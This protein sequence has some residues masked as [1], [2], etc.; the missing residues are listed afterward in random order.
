VDKKEDFGSLVSKDFKIGDIVEWS[1]WNSDQHKWKYLYG[2]IT[3]L[4][5]QVKSGRLVSVATVLPLSGS[6]IEIELFTMSL[7]LVS[8]KENDRE[9]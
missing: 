4:I 6:R 8:R 9:Q 7:R 5:N 3:R 2:V 1:V